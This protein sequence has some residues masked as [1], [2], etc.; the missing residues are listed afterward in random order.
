MEQVYASQY[1]FADFQRRLNEGQEALRELV[2]MLQLV[3]EVRQPDKVQWPKEVCGQVVF[4]QVSFAY[5]EGQDRALH[6]VSLTI[7]PFTTVALVGRSGSGKTTL[8]SLIQRQYDPS[9]GAIL[10]DGCDLRQLDYDRY[11]REVLAVVSQQVQL[12]DGSIRD[13]IRWSWTEAPVGAEEAAAKAAHAD[14]FIRRLPQGYDTPIGENGVKLS[15]GQRQRLAIARALLRQ[16]KVLILD[17]ATSALDSESQAAV[18]ASIRELTERRSCTIV[19]IAHRFSTVEQADAIVV[20]DGG[21][22]EEVGTHRQLMEKGGLYHRLHQLDGQGL[23]AEG[24]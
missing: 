19:I 8:A 22:V 1:R 10:V 21:R 4:D 17:E 15:G 18:Q 2:Q 9:E 7:E 20:M 3:P 12:F 11:R 6:R 23:L 16:P 13:N 24:E 14:E 5:P